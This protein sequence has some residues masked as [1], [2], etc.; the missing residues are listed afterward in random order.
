MRGKEDVIYLDCNLKKENQP[1]ECI[2]LIK[3]Q[4][5][6]EHSRTEAEQMMVWRGATSK[7]QQ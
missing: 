7:I 6:C 5:E 3:D 1:S 2:F 4:Y